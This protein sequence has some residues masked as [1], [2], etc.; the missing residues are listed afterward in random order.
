MIA[1]IA[2]K[3][4]VSTYQYIC[5]RVGVVVFG[6]PSLAQLVREK[7]SLSEK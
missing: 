5:D 3:L 4:G 6:M 2:K 7:S 1:Q